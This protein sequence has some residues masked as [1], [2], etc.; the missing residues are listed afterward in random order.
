MKD[1]KGKHKLV[2]NDEAYTKH[3]FHWEWLKE[4]LK[5]KFICPICRTN[6][7]DL[8][9]EKVQNV[10]EKLI[11]EDINDLYAE[12]IKYLMDNIGGEVNFKL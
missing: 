9:S 6:I 4:W 5:V 10:K 12:D 2:E 11:P 7:N 3:T 8:Y 1:K